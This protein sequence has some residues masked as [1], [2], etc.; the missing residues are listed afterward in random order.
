MK[1]GLSFY[2]YGCLVEGCHLHNK[3][4]AT[5]EK[6]G[7][8]LYT[9]IDDR[10]KLRDILGLDFGSTEDVSSFCCYSIRPFN[11]AKL[12]DTIMD[13]NFLLCGTQNHI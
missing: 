10:T 5:L 7:V 1:L 12:E 13:M 8:V 6:Y 3:K 2:L 9:L 4:E 11:Y